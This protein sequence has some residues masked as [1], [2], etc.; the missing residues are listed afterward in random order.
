MHNK[1]LKRWL[2]S[3]AAD[4]TP[5]MQTCVDYLG[6]ELPWLLRFKDTPQDREWHAEGDVFI[7]TD[8]VLSELYQL[9]ASEAQAIQGER[10]QALILGALLHDIGKP[11]QT[12]SAILQ[13]KERVIAPQHEAIGRSYLANKIQSWGLPF[14]VVWTVLQLVGEHHMPKQ[15]VNRNRPA[16]AFASL[17]RQVDLEL[18]Y[19]LE[20]ADMRGRISPDLE[21]QLLYLEEFKAL[22]ERYGVWQ[23]PLDIRPSLPALKDLPTPAQDYVYAHALYQWEQERIIQVEEALATTYSHR[24]EHAHLVLTCGASGAGKSTWIA[25]NLPDYQV[26]SLDDLRETISGQR[27]RQEHNGQ[28]RQQAK[29][30]LKAAL[31][32]KRN[33]VWDATNLRQDFREALIQLGRDYHALVTLVVFLLPEE[34]IITYN[35]QREHSV[36]D[37]VL[38]KQL[39]AYQ[40]PSL[41]EAHQYKV[42]GQDGKLLYRSGYYQDGYDGFC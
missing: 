36:P 16:S 9:L 18:L 20:V 23:Q 22:A 10:R 27:A 41:A 40:L 12:R 11:K 24:L 28:V 33:V 32:N 14:R 6:A 15:L 38:H 31:R 34:E 7:H 19:W 39:E 13:G 26:I 4:A 8:M 35:R 2:N 17:A 5:S 25:K 29:E 3:L 42:V 1:A 21:L 30:D 37:A